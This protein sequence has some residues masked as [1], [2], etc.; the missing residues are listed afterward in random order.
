MTEFS[1]NPQP[2]PTPKK[3]SEMTPEEIGEMIRS[4]YLAEMKRIRYDF[5]DDLPDELISPATPNYRIYKCR[6]N[7]L[8]QVNNELVQLLRFGV[9][10]KP[11]SIEKAQE[12]LDYWSAKDK[13]KF[14]TKEDIDYLNSTLDYFI[15]DLEEDKSG[16]ETE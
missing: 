2:E 7:V 4:E 5:L 12:Y 15:T 16:I 9:I 10:K 6:N 8:Y 14:N 3:T 1:H 13:E 11:Q